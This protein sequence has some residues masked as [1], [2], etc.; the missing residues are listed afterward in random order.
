MESKS[1]RNV[2]NHLWISA[3]KNSC[4]PLHQHRKGLSYVT[5]C[6]PVLGLIRFLRARSSVQCKLSAAEEK[7]SSCLRESQLESFS[8]L[9][10][11]GDWHYLQGNMFLV[12]SE[13]QL[14][15]EDTWVTWCDCLNLIGQR[16]LSGCCH[17]VSRITVVRNRSKT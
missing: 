3:R 17:L 6:L 7:L 10:P 8:P 9:A 15:L 16:K 14:W 11:T 2:L 13:T 1:S 12:M 4:V 5:A